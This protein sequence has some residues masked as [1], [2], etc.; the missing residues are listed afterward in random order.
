[1][2]VVEVR[3]IFEF[4]SKLKLNKFEKEVRI[5]LLKNYTEMYTVYKEQEAKMEELKKK[6][7]TEDDLKAF[8]E[9]LENKKGLSQDLINKN[10]EYN[11]VLSSLFDSECDI[12]VTKISE[13]KFVEGLV[14]S[15]TDFT[16][17]DI[18]RLKPIFE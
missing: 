1:M 16:P 2:K 4:L 10:N 17:I 6:I 14:E 7:F 8:Q 18:I 9:A 3:I 12:K 13:D 15:D 11:S 5:A